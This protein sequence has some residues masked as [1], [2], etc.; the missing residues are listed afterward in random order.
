MD[1][2]E[3]EEELRNLRSRRNINTSHIHSREYESTW[4]KFWD[5]TKKVFKYVAPIV[6]RYAVPIAATAAT[7]AS[8][9]PCLLM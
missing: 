4:S 5:G 6:I 9:M 3:L 8:H 7:V 1:E 2:W